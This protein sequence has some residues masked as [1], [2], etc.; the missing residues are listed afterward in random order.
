M[1][2]RR[3]REG[4]LP[5]IQ[6]AQAEAAAKTRAAKGSGQTRQ[7]KDTGRARGS[8]LPPFMFFKAKPD[9]NWH[10]LTTQDFTDFPK[11]R[12][13]CKFTADKGA[14][15]EMMV[16]RTP[17]PAQVS[18]WGPHTTTSLAALDYYRQAVYES[19]K[20]ATLLRGASDIARINQGRNA[21]KAMVLRPLT[22]SLRPEVMGWMLENDVVPQKSC[23]QYNDKKVT[24]L[25]SVPALEPVSFH[26]V[27]YWIHPLLT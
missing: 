4:K 11:F 15:M 7:E 22:Q 20:P 13:L 14:D 25:A 10:G 6:I 8:L 27:Y 1:L 17:T 24:R 21:A 5:E 26:R 9:K 18:K 2:F 12:Q 16:T 23:E 19:A 3:R